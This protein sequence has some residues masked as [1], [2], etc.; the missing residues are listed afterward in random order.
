MDVATEL[1]APR[2]EALRERLV[3]EIPGWYSPWVHLAFP[4]AVGI[5]LMAAALYVLHAPSWPELLF[6]LGVFLVSNASEWRAHRD[7]LHKKT[8][9]LEIIF[10]RHTPEHHGVYV[11]DDLAMRSTK[12]FRLVLIP[13]YGIV[14]IFAATSPITAALFL[15]GQTNLAAVF[16]FVTMFYVVSYEWLHLSYHLRPESFIGRRKI[17]RLLRRHHATHHH[18]PLMQ[19]WNFNVTLPLWDWVRGTIYKGPERAQA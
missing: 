7:I 15:G 19:A 1:E 18:P 14:T 10:Q 16:V 17:I 12:E 9:P 8:W 11:R 5:G 3:R 2:R 13:A 6:G 4:S